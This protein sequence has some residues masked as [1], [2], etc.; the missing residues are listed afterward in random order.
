MP[1]ISFSDM[2]RHFRFR[3]PLI[4]SPDLLPVVTVC[5]GTILFTLCGVI[6]LLNQRHRGFQLLEQPVTVIQG[7]HVYYTSPKNTPDCD[8]CCFALSMTDNYEQR[9]SIRNTWGSSCSVI[10]VTGGSQV[11]V[12]FDNGDILHVHV[13]EVYND[14]GMAS[15]LTTKVL[16]SVAYFET[17]PQKSR[18]M[19]KTD[20]D[21]YV[22]VKKVR[23]ALLSG[24][25]YWGMA[26]KNT[27]VLRLPWSRF[28]VSYDAYQSETFPDYAAGC[29]YAMSRLFTRCV[30]T[31]MALKNAPL[32]P[33]EDVSIGGFAKLC[34]VTLTDANKDTMAIAENYREKILSRNNEVSPFIIEHKVKTPMEMVKRHITK[35]VSCGNE[36]VSSDD[37]NWRSATYLKDCPTDDFFLRSYYVDERVQTDVSKAKHVV[38][39]DVS[40]E[41]QY[42]VIGCEI[43]NTR[44]SFIGDGWASVRPVSGD[45]ENS[46]LSHNFPFIKMRQSIITCLTANQ[47]LMSS[48]AIMLILETKSNHGSEYCKLKPLLKDGHIRK[49]AHTT[50][51]PRVQACTAVLRYASPAVSKQNKLL[52]YWFDHLRSLGIHGITMYMDNCDNLVTD[53]TVDIHPTLKDNIAS[54]FV[55]LKEWPLQYKWAQIIRGVHRGQYDPNTYKEIDVGDGRSF[56]WSQMLAITDCMYDAAARNINYAVSLDIDEFLELGGRSI[57]FIAKRDTAIRLP[58]ILYNSTC[59]TK[60]CPTRF[61]QPQECFDPVTDL[62]KRSIQETNSKFIVDPRMIIDVDPHIPL[63]CLDENYKESVC[64]YTVLDPVEDAHV[65]HL[66]GAN[67]ATC[68]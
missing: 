35:R 19:F 51:T 10:F 21:S 58:W 48:A 67:N 20:D 17:L 68:L 42:W 16:V 26:H 53:S 25:L 33:M 63:T 12:D 46:W 40:K 27:E 1:I 28:F 61:I 22:D 44:G 55:T 57:P 23:N 30:Q 65:A 15:S 8:L 31:K 4:K 56:H 54:G 29:G 43:M 39:A 59:N 62:F 18:Y 47:G 7:Q 49:Q 50:S 45:N 34:A 14:K 32:T 24:P 52:S 38:F 13:S 9:D 11:P 36:C 60:K 2:F 6:F 5:L 37:R 64:P 41:S 66:R 3:K